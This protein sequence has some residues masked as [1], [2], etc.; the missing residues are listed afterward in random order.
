MALGLGAILASALIVLW[1]DPTGAASILG[2]VISPIAA[3]IG[4]YFGVQV[5]GSAAKDAQDRAVAAQKDSAKAV[6]D[7]ATVLGALDPQT[8]K[9]ST[10]KTSLPTETTYATGR[11]AAGRG[12]A[13][14]SA[15]ERSPDHPTFRPHPKHAKI[16]SPRGERDVR[17][18]ERSSSLD[19]HSWSISNTQGGKARLRARRGQDRTVT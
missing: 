18:H 13:G 7:R 14:T 9:R 4:A 1:R 10:A 5:S 3:V 16:V 11:R 6:A 19:R 12:S 2:I 15:R 8:A 17:I